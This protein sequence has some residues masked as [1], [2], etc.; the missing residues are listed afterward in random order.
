MLCLGGFE[1]FACILLRVGTL[2]LTVLQFS[3]RQ[4]LL[5]FEARGSGLSFPAQDRELSVGHG[6]LG[7]GGGPLQL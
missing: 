1:I 7:L 3:H 2:F 4:A 5:T 6:P